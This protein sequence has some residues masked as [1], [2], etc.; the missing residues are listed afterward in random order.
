MEAHQHQIGLGGTGKL[1]LRVSVA[2]LVRLLFTNPEDGRTMLALER[3]AT[4]MEPEG[5]P[6][7]V[8]KAKPYGGAVQLVDP[9]GLRRRLA[10]GFHYDS[11]RSR[12]ERDFRILVRPPAW[13]TI[14]R[15]CEEHLD[16]S[17]QR[18]LDPRPDRELAEEFH[19]GLKIRLDP[20]RYSLAARGMIVQD[21]PKETDNVR[22]KGFPT[23]RVYYLFTAR[24]A[25]PELIAAILSGNKRFSDRDLQR[26]A[27]E[28]ARQGGRGRANAVL[29]LPLDDVESAYRL[30]PAGGGPIKIGEHQLDGNVLAL[31]ATSYSTPPSFHYIRKEETMRRFEKEKS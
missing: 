12:R 19:D 8:V 22:A 29:A 5:R 9:E 31:F 23:A 18:I 17:G 13:E 2:A 30:A 21:L 28:D 24:I 25:D 26:L 16:E 3:T 4:L 27:W 7:V 1:S 20:S 14:K 10:G 11:R 15:I 6:E